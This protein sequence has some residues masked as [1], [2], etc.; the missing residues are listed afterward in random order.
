MGG[1]RTLRR[2]GLTGEGAGETDGVVADVDELLH[3]ADALLG[4][5]AHLERDQRAQVLEVLPQLVADLS[6]DLSSLGGRH[7]FIYFDLKEE[8]INIVLY[9]CNGF[10]I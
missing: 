7:L 5:L 1:R 3:L 9:Q 2:E 4:D 8:L 10:S 6:D